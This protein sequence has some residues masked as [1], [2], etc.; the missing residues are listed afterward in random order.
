MASRRGRDR[1]RRGGGEPLAAAA[2]RFAQRTGYLAAAY[3]YERAAELTPEPAQRGER[4][5]A[6]AEAS[7]LAGRPAHARE[8][9]EEAEPLAEDASLRADIALKEAMLEAWLG[10]VEVAA[11]ALRAHRRG[12]HGT[13]IRTAGRSRSRSPPAPPSRPGDTGSALAS[14]RRAAALLATPGLSESTACT[15]RETLGT[16]LVLRGE[17]REGAPLLREAAAWFERRGELPG[18][19]LRGP[20]AAVGRGLRPGA[21][22]ARPAARAREP[23][24]RPTRAHLRAR[25]PGAARRTAPGTGALLTPPRRSPCGCRRDT[26]LTVQLAYSL[27][28]LAIVEAAQGRRPRPRTPRR[29]TRSPRATGST[30]IAEYTGAAAGLDAL[31]RGQPHEA[32]AAP[33]E[34]AERVGAHRPASARRPAVGGRPA[35]GR[36]AHETSSRRRAGGWPRSS[37]TPRTRATPGARPSRRASP[38]CSPTTTGRTSRK[39]YAG[40]STRRRRSRRPARGSASASACAAT[41][42]GSRHGSS[43]APPRRASGDWAPRRGSEAAERELSATGERL[44]RRAPAAADELTAQER[45]IAGLVA[46][47]GSNKDVAAQLFLSTKTVEAHLTRIYRKLGVNSRTQLARRLDEERQSPTAAR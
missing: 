5:V 27:G 24:G 9:L 20:G 46:A 22:P 41:A 8:L 37:A 44:R 16:V 28:V 7:R 26:E 47:G 42:G 19:R 32:L 38:A 23:G 25:G 40:T 43:F 45:E 34:V 39:R 6:A 29:P 21:P 15:V 1:S 33:R 18:S 31:G 2:E 10:S 36:G 14:A 35:R 4:L 11:R 13:A 3:A 17:P 30:V 12:G